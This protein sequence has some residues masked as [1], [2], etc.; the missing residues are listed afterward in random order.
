VVLWSLIGC[1]IHLWGSHDPNQR[2]DSAGLDSAAPTDADADGDSD[3]DTDADADADA[4]TDTNPD[5]ADTADTGDPPDPNLVTEWWPYFTPDGKVVCEIV[6]KRVDGVEWSVATGSYLLFPDATQLRQGRWA[7]GW[8]GAACP[9]EEELLPEL[10]LDVSTPITLAANSEAA[11]LTH[12]LTFDVTD[13]ALWV[14]TTF[15]P[16]LFDVVGLAET[17]TGVWGPGPLALDGPKYALVVIDSGYV[18]THDMND[19]CFIPLEGADDP[20]TILAGVD[21]GEFKPRTPPTELQAVLAR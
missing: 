16:A 3:T 13:Q 20:S 1:T 2:V 4:D 11:P 6:S 18:Q 21:D 8:T 12:I 17:A 14:A 5:T 19:F 15:E 7:M 9:G 10:L